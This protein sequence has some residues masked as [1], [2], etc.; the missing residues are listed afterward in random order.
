MELHP[1][2]LSALVAVVDLGT[3]EAAARQLRVTPSAISQRMKALESSVGRVLLTRSKPVRATESGEIVLR[4]ARQVALLHADAERS[5]EGEE[6]DVTTMPLAINADSL[7]TWA[8]PALAEV[9]TRHRLVFDLY[10]EDQAHTTELLRQGTVMG[11]VTSEPT[12]VQGCSVRSI[13]RMRYRPMASP[14]F[15]ER[16]FASG[17]TTESFAVAPLVEFDRRDTLQQRYLDRRTAAG[18]HPP[19]HYIPTSVDFASAVMLGLGWGML[20]DAQCVEEER[21]GLLVQLDPGAETIVP[22]YWQQ[23]RLESASLSAVADALSNAAPR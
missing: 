3:F 11:A 16:W 23:W 4:L 21:A 10:R 15:A 8:L 6:V 9:A 13:G 19:R 22:L 12:A 1:D 20:P 7:A 18:V 5:L 14:A 17:A 2:Q